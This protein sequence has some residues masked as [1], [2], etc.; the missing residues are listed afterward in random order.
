MGRESLESNLQILIV[1]IR[2][3][4]DDGRTEGAVHK[5]DYY[6]RLI[7]MLAY[8]QYLRLWERRGEGRPPGH[9]AQALA[10]CRSRACPSITINHSLTEMIYKPRDNDHS[11]MLASEC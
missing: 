3:I 8:L 11:I 6:C 9:D 4:R 1:A 2:T 5:P 10:F 7:R